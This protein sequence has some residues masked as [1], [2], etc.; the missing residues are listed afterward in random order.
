MLPYEA[1]EARARELLPQAVFDYF[2]GGSG[3]EATLADNTAAWARLRLRPRV[4]RDVSSVDTSTELLG[5]PLSSPVLVAPT[6]FHSLAHPEAELATARGTR[7]ARSLLVL[8]SRSSRRI[9]DVAS[10]A[11]PWWFQVYVFR[12]RGLTRALVQRAAAAGARALVLT[13]D[14][15]YVGRKRQNRG[16]SA[17]PLPEEDFLANLEGLTRRELAEQAPDITFADISR[18]RED[19]GL[20]VLVK[21]VLRAD[22]ARECLHHGA[23]GLIV[24]NHGGRQLDG[25]VATADALPEVVEASEGRV[26]VLVDGGVRSGRDVLRALALGARAVL[27]G[28][29]VLWGLALLGA[30]GVRQVLEALRED[31][32]HARALS[33]QSRLSAVGPDVLAPRR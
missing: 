29:P 13:G 25:A 8:S 26:P 10:A 30:D 31:T 2:A 6:A 16:D 5:T 12:D 3:D 24:S 4:L 7:E 28:R 33:G 19:S 11:G 15:P 17:L 14:T 21:G 32:A 18:L 23:A 9:E 27:L 22:D 1:L 20:P